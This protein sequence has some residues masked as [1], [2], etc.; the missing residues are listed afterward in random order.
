MKSLIFISL[1]TSISFNCF[2]QNVG[3]GT[4]SPDPSALLE[5]SA[6]NRGVLVPRMNSVQRGLIATPATGL[7]VYDTDT[8]GF[9]FFNGTSWTNLSATLVLPYSNETTSALP[10]FSI[11]NNGSGAALRSFGISGPAL[12]ASGSAGGLVGAALRVDN[13]HPGAIGLISTTSSA[14]ANMVVA[15]AGTGDIIRGFSGPSAGTL[16]YRLLNDGGITTTGKIAVGS[17]LPA[18]AALEVTGSVKIMDGT[19]AGGR[20]LTADGTGLAS[21]VTPAALNT[22]FQVKKFGGNLTPAGNVEA[23]VNFDYE[24]FD[25]AAAF[26]TGAGTY[27]CPASGVY[28][29]NA[30]IQWQ[31]TVTG[32]APTLHIYL[33]VN[34]VAVEENFIMTNYQPGASA[35]L[36]VQIAATLK[37]NAGDVVKVVAKHVAG[38]G[39]FS[40]GTVGTTFSGHRVY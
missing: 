23:T 14:D 36:P 2:C 25:D 7:L 28:D 40:V 15:N 35:A 9:W 30:R 11:K 37:L 5:L 39:T 13:A 22:G 21:W 27:T 31:L 4:T 19:Q 17:S 29:F 20:V 8:A 10:A 34:N 26:T 3:I 1:L 16:V 18:A 33:H 6:I 38:T 12:W 24:V 32:A